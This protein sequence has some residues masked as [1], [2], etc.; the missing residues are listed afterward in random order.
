MDFTA[1]RCK[2]GWLLL[3]DEGGR[4]FFASLDA[5]LAV[6]PNALVVD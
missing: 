4:E 6:A 1:I 5:L 3:D 2:G